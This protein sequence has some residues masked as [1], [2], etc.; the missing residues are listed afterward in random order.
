MNTLLA[1]LVSAL[2]RAADHNRDDTVTPTAMLWPDEKG[3]W[4]KLVPRSGR[5]F[6]NS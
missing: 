3:E 4:E 1:S 2:Q 5:Y 6:H